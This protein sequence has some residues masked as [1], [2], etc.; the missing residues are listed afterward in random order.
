LNEEEIVSHEVVMSL[1]DILYETVFN[2]DND[3]IFVY[4]VETRHIY[5]AWYYRFCKLAIEKKTVA[6]FELIRNLADILQISYIRKKKLK[7]RYLADLVGFQVL[8]TNQLIIAHNDF[9]LFR[10]EINDFSLLLPSETPDEIQSRLSANLFV[11]LPIILYRDREFMKEVEKRIAQIEYLVKHE[12]SKNFSSARTIQVELED[13]CDFLAKQLNK[14]QDVEYVKAILNGQPA[15]QLQQQI[16]Q[17]QK[18]IVELSKHFENLKKLVYTLYLT[19]HVCKTFFLIGAYLLFSK[20]T[21]GT[22]AETYIK[23]LWSHTNPDDA[24]GVNLNRPPITSNPLW[25]TYLR[26]YGGV[27]SGLWLSLLSFGDFHGAR[28]YIDRYYLLAIEKKKSGLNAPSISQLEK[29]KSDGRILELGH[30]FEFS[31]D[32]VSLLKSQNFVNSCDSLIE[33]AKDFNKLLS[34]KSKNETGEI[35]VTEAKEKLG[36]LKKWIEIKSSE[37]EE[38]KEKVVTLLPL[39]PKRVETSLE[40]MAHSY[41]RTSKVQE[42]AQINPYVEGKDGD[43]EFV[44]I[45]KYTQV[46]KDCLTEPSETDCSAI[47]SEFGK[48]IAFGEI[49]YFIN[50]MKENKEVKRLKLKRYSADK[51]LKEIETVAKDLETNGFSPSTIFMP[52]SYWKDTEIRGH[53]V[54]REQTQFLKINNK[55]LMAIGSS[56]YVPFEDIIIMD[57]T[58]I[59]WTFKQGKFASNRL[60]INVTESTENASSVAVLIKTAIKLE[61]KNPKAATILKVGP[62]KKLGHRSSRK[63]S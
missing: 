10:S 21:K 44:Q 51:L 50:E 61:I 49:N 34:T 31:H 40:E 36:D 30:W 41:E 4:L 46:P 56:N 6:R 9:D 22:D 23:E 12:S 5:G 1:F 60:E 38:A 54:Y 43:R 57:K 39:D 20:A 3:D 58:G 15:D 32:L 53:F 27:G 63:K 28:E 59:V 37:F 17:T 55:E 45:Y 14:L 2:E 26:L 29:M 8:R 25:L 62:R 11:N 18:Y 24:D 7:D 35:H 52:L 33:E 13:Y 16:A 42:I 48:I 47:W 19:S